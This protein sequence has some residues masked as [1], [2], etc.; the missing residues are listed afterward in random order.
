[1][2]NLRVILIPKDA[3]IFQVDLKS[4]QAILMF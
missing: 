1:M 2:R 3:F 4:L